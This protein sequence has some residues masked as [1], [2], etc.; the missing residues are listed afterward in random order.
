[1][2]KKRYAITGDFNS[3][4]SFAQSQPV[5][6][7]EEEREA[8]I[9]WRE[10]GCQAARDKLILSHLKI[11]CRITLKNRGYGL[12]L[13]DILSEAQTGLA[14][15]VD[16]FD[17]DKGFRFSSYARWWITAAINEYVIR[18]WSIVKISNTGAQKKLF[19]GLRR[20][21]A[22]INAMSDSDMTDDQVR[23]IS[24][25]MDVSEEEVIS[26][27]R[28]LM[29]EVSLN[30]QI[31]SPD[32]IGPGNELIDTIED[33]ATLN[34][35]EAYA[36]KEEQ[37]IR[38]QAL[39]VALSSLTDRERIIVEKRVLSDDP[40]TFNVLAEEFNVSRERIRQIET[41]AL[42]KLQKIVVS[43]S[44]KIVEHVYS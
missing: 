7:L 27:N 16:R 13:E 30:T 11:A 29:G 41:R 1:M 9:A 37:T 15:A 17:V 8:A 33:E 4:L 14:M 35:E 31:G 22:Q 43:E 24:K 36:N 34:P 44:A 12:P 5:L 39:D 18:S 21:K 20:A 23:Q 42:E 32:G 10:H 26:M 6:T 3:W 28:R 2:D 19:F 25:M 38:Q 40:V